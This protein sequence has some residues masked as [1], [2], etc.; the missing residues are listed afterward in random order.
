LAQETF[1]NFDPSCAIGIY[2]CEYVPGAG[3]TI[4]LPHA[5]PKGM[6]VGFALSDGLWQIN[7][8]STIPW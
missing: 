5:F 1:S 6:I 3:S 7:Q 8:I 4:V 2:F